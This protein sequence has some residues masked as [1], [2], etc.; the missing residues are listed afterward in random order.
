M[1]GALLSIAILQV[2]TIL[3]GLLRA[4]GLAILLGPAGF[5]VVSTIDQVV[6]TAISLGALALPFTAL[7]FM[8]RSHSA[9]EAAF[10]QVASTFVRVL[11]LLALVLTTLA[12]VA[13][14]MWPSL[15]GADLAGYSVSIHL[16]LLGIP[17]AM[18][19]ILFVNTL[20][21]AT[22]PA[23]A[24]GLNLLMMVA[25]GVGAIGGVV[26]GGLSG[27]YA[28]NAVIGAA[29]L[30]ASILYLRRSVGLELTG[31]GVR[32]MAELR[33]SP[34]IIAY[35]SC[36][37]VAMSTYGLSLLAIRSTVLA[38][39]GEVPAGLL[40]VSLSIALT[41]GAVLN[42]MSNLYLAPVVNRQIPL[43]EKVRAAN[44]FG[45]KVLG[46]LLLGSLPV[47]LFPRLLVVALYSSAF[48]AAETT[49]FLFVLWQCIYQVANVYHQLLV[50]LDDVF[51][52]SAAA[53][54]GYGSAAAIAWLLVPKVGLGGAA[55]ALAL[56]MTIYGALGIIG[57]RMRHAVAVPTP[58]LARVGLVL[59][60][61]TAAGRLFGAGIGETTARGVAERLGYGMAAVSLFWVLLGSSERT[62]LRQ[63]GRSLRSLIARTPIGDG[64][65]PSPS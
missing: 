47:L 40:Q 19:H 51:F 7:K 13:L 60:L 63:F 11:G 18:L 45:L 61:V 16:A 48:I 37:Y 9:G 26:V 30:A 38:Q 24:A 35:A 3:V 6:A 31:S 21:A 39:L 62:E 42:T 44:D 52:M 49:V 4:K 64:P 2:L 15:F 1:S 65:G 22:R 43:E 28:V 36:L 33:R 32:I 5:G 46:L 27:L 58:M 14:A 57:L 53:T 25:L 17:A 50:G 10:R 20:A 54:A 8:A 55:I 41:V 12:S 29:A 23:A 59:V 56:G 34:E